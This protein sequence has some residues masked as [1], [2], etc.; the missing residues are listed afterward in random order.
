MRS[1]PR[2]LANVFDTHLRQVEK[3]GTHTTAKT[4]VQKGEPV[5]VEEPITVR[6]LSAALGIKTNDLQGRL[7]K[8]GLPAAINQTLDQATAETIA[9][10]LGLELEIARKATLEEQFL[11]TMQSREV[12][13]EKLQLRPPVVTI[14]GHVDHGKTSL[15]DKIRNAHVAAGEAGGITQHTAAWMVQLGEKR[16]TFIDTPGHQAFTSMRARGANMTGCGGA[17]GIRRRRRAAA[18]D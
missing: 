4:I 6:S 2:Q 15:L 12:D 5:I 10:D 16:V 11:K 18:D 9:L 8:L 13:P 3:R 17:G 14:L 1:M 7:M